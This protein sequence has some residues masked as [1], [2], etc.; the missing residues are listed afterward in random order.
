MPGLVVFASI[1][2]GWMGVVMADEPSAHEYKR[3]AGPH[4]V[5]EL[6]DTW[7]DARRKRELPVKV[8]YPRDDRGPVPVILFSHGLGG[9]RETYAY[10][11]RHWAGHGYVVVHVQHI[12]SDDSVWKG[13][14]QQ[15]ARMKQAALDPRNALNRPADIHF[16][17]DRLER[18]QAEDGPLKGRLD[19]SRVGM[20]G[21]SFGAHTTLAVAGQ[22]FITPTGR[23]VTSEDWRIKA[24]VIMSPN[25]PRQRDRLDEVYAGVHIP[26][27]HM[28]GTRDDSPINDSKPADRR[29]AFDHIKGADQ[30]LVTLTDGDHM[31]FS[32]R[33]RLRG[34][35]PNRDAE[36]Q[37]LIRQATTAFWDAYL[38]NDPAARRWLQEGGCEKL[39]GGQ[40]VLEKKIATS[41]PAKSG[42]QS[43]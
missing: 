16:A 36:F 18:L 24:A 27:L 1:V 38:K 2:S 37:L 33:K 7:T 11:G 9:S 13:Q 3:A 35:E 19:L 42:R 12:G 30:Y 40:A 32:G 17:L 39:L 23:S 25:A 10:L 43:D 31:V 14:T 20:G 41:R 22:A 26:A 5:A 29:V 28:T 21:H 15:M 4:P 6:L 34:D 8:Y